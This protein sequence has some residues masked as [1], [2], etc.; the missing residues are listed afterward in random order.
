MEKNKVLYDVIAK[1]CAD[2]EE[3]YMLV[4]GYI[5]DYVK[6]KLNEMNINSQ[7]IIDKITEKLFERFDDFGNLSEEKANKFVSNFIEN[8]MIIISS[9]IEQ[10]YKPNMSKEQILYAIE[11]FKGMSAENYKEQIEELQEL[12]KQYND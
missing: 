12:L 10:E 4:N 1:G 9:D 5:E 11:I 8:E 7:E 6:E 2:G 3:A